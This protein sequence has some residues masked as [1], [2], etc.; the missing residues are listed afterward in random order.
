MRS[1]RDRIRRLLVRRHGR[2]FFVRGHRHVI[3]IAVLR[4]LGDAENDG[5]VAADL[6]KTRK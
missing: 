3:V 1:A 5:F 2:F 4:S 6:Q